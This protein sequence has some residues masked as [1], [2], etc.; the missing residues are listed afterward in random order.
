MVKSKAPVSLK[1]TKTA[2]K[3]QPVAHKPAKAGTKH[4]KPVP[5]KAASA[6]TPTAKPVPE[7]KTVKADSAPQKGSKHKSEKGKSIP[8]PA[9]SGGMRGGIMEE[10]TEPAEL[11][12]KP[13]GEGEDGAGAAA[14]S[15]SWEERSQ[16]IKDLVKLAEEQGY[17]TFDDVNEMIPNSVINPEEL[18]GYLELLRSMDIEIIEA[19]DAEKF[20]KEPAKQTTSVARAERLDIF[21]DPIRMYLHQMGQ[22][23][24]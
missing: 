17:L 11:E 18:E 21:D 22:V 14:G 1:A 6:K 2:P 7:T 15:L 9:L 24:L 19:S 20:R 16:R 4:A 23:P 12:T 13:E 8:A 3:A 5:E 10:G